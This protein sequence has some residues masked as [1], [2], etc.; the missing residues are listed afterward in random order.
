MDFLSIIAFATLQALTEFLPVSSSAHLY[1]LDFF[2]TLKSSKSFDV[3]LHLGTIIAIMVYFYK[4]I[5]TLFTQLPSF[6]TAPLASKSQTI[7]AIVFS[8]V[9]AVIFGLLITFLNLDNY[10]RFLPFVAFNLMFFGVILFI[11]DTKMPQTIAFNNITKKQGFFIGLAQALALM[12]GV[13]RSGS[14]FTMARFLNIKKPDAVKFSML[15]SVPV[16]LGAGI[17]QFAT[18]HN[19]SFNLA[20]FLLGG[21][22]SFLLGLVVIRFLLF[23]IANFS[24]KIFMVYRIVLGLLILVLYFNLV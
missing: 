11:A 8:A 2:T 13:S 15:I 3:A 14:C 10:L 12:P 18:L 21:V 24:F 20:D 5:I 6:F 22:I 19:S 9:P 23:F 16:I 7:T 1:I 4:D 17:L